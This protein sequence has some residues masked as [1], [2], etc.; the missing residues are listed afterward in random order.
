MKTSPK[1]TVDRRN[2][3][4]FSAYTDEM[5]SEMPERRSLRLGWIAEC[6]MPLWAEI[7][8]C[9]LTRASRIFSYEERYKKKSFEHIVGHVGIVRFLQCRFFCIEQPPVRQAILRPSDWPGQTK[10]TI[11]NFIVRGPRLE[12]ERVC[13]C[14]THI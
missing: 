8:R 9:L 4:T 5:A 14:V 3:Y 10:F 12:R 1:P 13:V 6:V 7:V 11:N 2:R